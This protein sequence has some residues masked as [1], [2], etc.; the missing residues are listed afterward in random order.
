MKRYMIAALVMIGTL[1]LLS[2]NGYGAEP[3]MAPPKK[4]GRSDR[5]PAGG[6]GDRTG[7]GERVGGRPRQL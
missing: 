4:R 6:A 2:L 3:M 7:E 1:G 5:R